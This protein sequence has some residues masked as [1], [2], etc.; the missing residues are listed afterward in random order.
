M[1]REFANID[2]EGMKCWDYMN[3]PGEYNMPALSFTADETSENASIAS[4]LETFISEMTIK[5]IIGSE[6]LTDSSWNAYLQKLSS[7]NYETL[8]SNYQA[9]YDRWLAK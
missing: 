1:D 4:D 2:E 7:M 5:W 9:A 8:V 3:T 6:E